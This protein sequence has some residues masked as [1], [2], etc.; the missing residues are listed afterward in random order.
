MKYGPIPESDFERRLLQ[1][2]G[3]PRLTLDTLVAPVQ[4]KCLMLAVR[5][6]VFEL[7]RDAPCSCAELSERL[8]V[9]REVLSLVLRMLWGN[10]YLS[11]ESGNY[12]LTSLARDHLLEESRA[13]RTAHIGL[14]ELLWGAVGNLE[15]AL[16]HGTG[17]DVHQYLRGTSE[18]RTYQ[19]AMLEDARTN[20][21]LIAPFIPVKRGASRLL[22]IGGSHGLYG[23]LICRAHPPMRSE[24]LE[25][26]SA[27]EHSRILAEEAG[28]TDIV[29]HRAGDALQDDLGS[30][31]DV[32]LL[33]NVLHHF[34]P[35]PSRELIGRVCRALTP[36]GT[37]AI[38]EFEP[39]EAEA[40]PD[41]V[42]DTAALLFR[43]VFGGR[44]HRPTDYVSWLAEAGVGDSQVRR[45]L[46]L[47][48]HCI[49]TGTAPR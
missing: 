9:D 1:T 7:L 16:R 3:G 34:A 19:A 36:G 21:R 45:S 44:C 31:F 47:P 17:C 13:R 2:A 6:G 30:G 48:Q 46:L 49:V 20:A 4:T 11:C 29:S 25:L 43:A 37:V 39:P 12:G 42:R 22:D 14:C 27:L 40:S 33:N 38:L 10:G 8:D 28:V 24:V 18:W 23:G 32:V 5:L 35:A 15:S 26:P 41:A